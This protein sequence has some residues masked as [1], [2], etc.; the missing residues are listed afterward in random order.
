MPINTVQ[1][2]AIVSGSADNVAAVTGFAAGWSWERWLLRAEMEK[3]AGELRLT[4]TVTPGDA[5][6]EAGKMVADVHA[7]VE[8]G[9]KVGS[10]FRMLRGYAR[11]PTVTCRLERMGT[12][13]V[14]L[15]L[16]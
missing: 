8:E 12:I 9:R 4:D 11:K 1:L 7:I 10:A 2:D 13:N 16:A 6:R 15:D 14:R 5:M 3:A